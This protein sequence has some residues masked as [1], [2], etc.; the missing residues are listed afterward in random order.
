M[1]E[2]D[3][4]VRLAT[5]GSRDMRE[6]LRS[7]RVDEPSPLALERLAA[8]LG[9]TLAPPATATSGLARPW[10]V[11]AAAGVI[12]AAS[13]VWWARE[14]AP[15]RPTPVAPRPLAPT[16]VAATPAPG[17]RSSASPAPVTVAATASEPR[18]AP[19]V[20]RPPRPSAAAPPT[21]VAAPIVDPPPAGPAIVLALEAPAAVA[22]PE[23]RPR[24]VDLLDPAHDALRSRDTA[25]ALDLAARHAEIYPSGAMAEE[26][27][28]IIIE[29]LLQ[30]GHR[31]AAQAGFDRFAARFPRSGYRSRLQRL[32]AAGR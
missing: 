17:A 22:A 14:P 23:P 21:V 20:R 27:E 18:S 11:I 25:R 2:H 31:E 13:V 5:G 4:P 8:R 30:L 16:A 28:A 10:L 7:A 9:P 1:S 32:L 6:L 19:A 24:E 15:Q 29:A 26:R 3:D 12:G